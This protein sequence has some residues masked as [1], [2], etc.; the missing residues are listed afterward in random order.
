MHNYFIDYNFNEKQ[1]KLTIKILTNKQFYKKPHLKIIYIM[2]TKL[3]KNFLVKGVFL[4]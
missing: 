3:W 4:L 1:K 2:L